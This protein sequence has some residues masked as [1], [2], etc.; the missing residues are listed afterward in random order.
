MQCLAVYERFDPNHDGEIDFNE[1]AYTFFNRRQF[2]EATK[3]MKRRFSE[4]LTSGGV[5]QNKGAVAQSSTTFKSTL[6]AHL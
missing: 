3:K 2:S 5:Q 6:P 1:F 4:G